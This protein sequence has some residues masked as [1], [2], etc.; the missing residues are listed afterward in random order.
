[1]PHKGALDVSR[2]IIPAEGDLALLFLLAERHVEGE[3]LLVQKLLGHHVVKEGRTQLSWP[4]CHLWVGEAANA[5]E[6]FI[7]NLFF[8]DDAYCMAFECNWIMHKTFRVTTETSYDHIVK[9]KE[10]FQWSWPK[11]Y[12]TA[13]CCRLVS[14]GLIRAE[15]IIAP[16]LKSRTLAKIGVSPE[17]CGTG[18]K[19]RI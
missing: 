19:D 7:K 18:V 6:R 1:M 9:C 13:K 16:W 10:S 4:G 5:V 2:W 12:R 15:W 17:V 11:L 3:S 8:R 14:R